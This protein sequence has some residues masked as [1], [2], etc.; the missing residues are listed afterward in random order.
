MIGAKPLATAAPP[1]DAQRAT[2]ESAAS[3]RTNAA[4]WHSKRLLLDRFRHADATHQPGPRALSL[5]AIFRVKYRA[6]ASS[7]GDI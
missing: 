7:Q 5:T 4:Y 6:P 3:D 1:R 2:P